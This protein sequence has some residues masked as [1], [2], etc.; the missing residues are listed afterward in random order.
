MQQDP[1]VQT[2]GFDSDLMPPAATS[3]CQCGPGVI[4]WELGRA[5]SRDLGSRQGEIGLK[6]AVRTWGLQF[7]CINLYGHTTPLS[8]QIAEWYHVHKDLCNT[9]F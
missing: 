6:D 9:G 8:A 7:C 2:P 3:L 1:T 5:K 4:D